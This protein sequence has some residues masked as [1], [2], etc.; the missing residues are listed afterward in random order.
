MFSKAA[1]MD[2]VGVDFPTDVPMDILL[3]LPTSSRRRCRLVC[4]HRRYAVDERTPERDVSTKILTFVKGHDRSWAYV[5]D[6]ARGRHR[7]VWTSSCSVNV[8]VTAPGASGHHIAL[9]H[10]FYHN[11]LNLQYIKSSYIALVPKKDQP[12]S[13]N[14]YSGINRF[15]Q[16]IIG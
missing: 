5:V 16:M 1:A 13:A 4:K 14:D 8:I 10:A 11:E 3:L 9:F 7:H 6:E 2:T 12:I 15:Q